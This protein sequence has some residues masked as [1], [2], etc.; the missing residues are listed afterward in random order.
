MLTQAAPVIPWTPRALSWGKSQQVGRCAQL[1]THS[2]VLRIHKPINE[3]TSAKI[4][5]ILQVLRKVLV[6]A[7]R[8]KMAD[9]GI[10]IIPIP[11]FEHIWNWSRWGWAL[12]SLVD[13]GSFLLCAHF[14]HFFFSHFGL[15]MLG[16]F[17]WRLPFPSIFMFLILSGC[18]SQ[19]SLLW[20][21]ATCTSL[22]YIHHLWKYHLLP[23]VVII[24]Y[25]DQICLLEKK[26]YTWGAIIYSE[27]RKPKQPGQQCP[28]H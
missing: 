15:L 4:S 26:N 24:K 23:L 11:W 16:F 2:S 12:W 19:S 14:T 5:E 22:V 17:L 7:L 20:C 25:Q 3:L 1:W 6:L 13:H 27:Q 10:W 28:F 21:K 18:P 9:L 8:L